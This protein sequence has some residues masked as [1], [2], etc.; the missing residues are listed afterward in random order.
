MLNS[1]FVENFRLF[2]RLEIARLGRV[3][4]LVGKN[5]SG[6]SAL[7][8]AI[9]IYASNASVQTLENIVSGRDE[10]WNGKGPTQTQQVSDNPIKHL[11]R[12]HHL[13]GIEEPG[14]S[15]GTSSQPGEHILLRTAAFQIEVDEENVSRRKRITALEASETASEVEISLI[16]QQG[17]KFARIIRLEPNFSV[18]WKRPFSQTVS[19]PI[20]ICQVV[21][22]RNM[23][24]HQVAAL[25]D[26]IALTNFGDEV[27]CGLKL[28]APEI[29]ALAFVEADGESNAARIPYIR[30]EN[31]LE[32]LPLKSMGDGM[33]RLLHIIIALVTA[34]N[35]ILLIDEFE[36]GLHWSVQLAV[37]R[38][39]FR[40]ATDLNVQVFAT[41]HSSDC[42]SSFEEACKEHPDDG[43]FIR[44][45]MNREGEPIA[46]IY[47][48]ET[49]ADSLDSDVEVR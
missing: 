13:P 33:T 45:Q 38:T 36:N 31:S 44:L 28:V 37:W 25:W 30:T 34:Q 3:N 6:K 17:Q 20:C 19:H 41:T 12:G 22:T 32:P 40:I 10:T 48:F 39:V 16:V 43:A 8:E 21:P 7:L 2:H 15:L 14:I 46:K 11:F 35:G 27:V 23:S 4:L 42:V 1:F 9:E 47:S 49:L 5:N 29:T 24:A 26:S 18:P